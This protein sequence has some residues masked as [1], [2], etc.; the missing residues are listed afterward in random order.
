MRLRRKLLIVAAAALMLAGPLYILG[1]GFFLMRATAQFLTA[2]KNLERLAQEPPPDAPFA[3][4]YRGDPEA[5]FG[6]PFETV[7]LDTPL[8][9]APAWLVGDMTECDM[10]GRDMTG[11]EMAAIYVHGVGGA[12]E[13][14]YRHLSMFVQAGVPTLLVTYRND[15]GAPPAPDGVYGFGLTEWRDVEAAADFL[16]ARGYGRLIL[17]GESMGGAIVGQFLRRSPRASA[18]AAVA[19]DSP[20]LDF[21]E[22]LRGFAQAAGLPLSAPVTGAALALMAASGTLDM[23]EAVT[24][25]DFAAFEGPL[26]VA[27]GSGDRIVPVQLTEALV[28]ARR[29]ATLHLRT[30]ADHLGSFAEDPEAYRAAFAGFLGMARNRAAR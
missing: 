15:P 22:I 13:D 24:I 23:R 19:L 30:G 7:M 3:I 27:H 12:R 17:V 5:A 11:R 20:A 14:G 25:A 4:G 18:V 16:L 28:A 9:P 29:D 21:P 2:E 8:G 26:F 6:L 10:T 1:A